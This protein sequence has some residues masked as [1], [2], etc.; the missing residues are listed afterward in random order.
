[1][2]KKIVLILTAA[3]FLPFAFAQDLDYGEDE[4][5]ATFDI[6]SAHTTDGTNYTISA[7]GE[8]GPYGRVW[9]SYEFTDKLGLGDSGEFTGFAWTQNGEHHE[10]GILRTHRE[11]GQHDNPDQGGHHRAAAN[12][13]GKV[14][15]EIGDDHNSQRH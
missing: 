1:M 7:T 9:L 5:I 14:S 15:E 4:F 12:D 13:S 11:E 6:D 3:L 2:L 10:Q 8:A